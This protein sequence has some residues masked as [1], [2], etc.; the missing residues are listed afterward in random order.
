MRFNHF[1]ALHKQL[2]PPMQ[3][4]IGCRDTTLRCPTVKRLQCLLDQPRLRLHSRNRFAMK[5][6]CEGIELLRG[7]HSV[8]MEI[9]A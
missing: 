4:R 2:A 6:Q 5:R 8:I 7:R 1:A 9:G 3:I